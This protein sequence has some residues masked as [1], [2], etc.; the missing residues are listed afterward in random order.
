MQTDTLSLHVIC[1]NR[2][3]L[4]FYDPFFSENLLYCSLQL[5]LKIVLYFANELV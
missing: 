3:A 4:I 5:N 1:L 2:W